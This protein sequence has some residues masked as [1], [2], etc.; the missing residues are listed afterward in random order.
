VERHRIE[1]YFTHHK[2]AH[3]VAKGNLWDTPCDVAL[4]CATQNELTG[5]DAIKLVKNGCVRSSVHAGCA[6]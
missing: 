6:I 4:P 2:H 1:D 5:K 3:Y